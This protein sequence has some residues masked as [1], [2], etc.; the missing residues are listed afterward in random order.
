LKLKMLEI[1]DC[2]VKSNKGEI[3]IRGEK[4]VEMVKGRKFL[5][6]F[7]QGTFNLSITGSPLLMKKLER[8]KNPIKYKEINFD[9]ILEDP[10]TT[11][12]IAEKEALQLEELD[13]SQ[14]LDTSVSLNAA[15]SESE[16]EE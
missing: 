9:L 12:K 8:K 10:E 2:Y 14:D 11:D 15:S 13:E 1:E 16:N 5:T 4:C 6:I 7:F 3:L